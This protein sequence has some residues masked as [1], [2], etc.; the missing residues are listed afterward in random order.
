MSLTLQW[1]T[2]DGVLEAGFLEPEVQAF[3]SWGR[4]LGVR[5]R[6]RGLDPEEAPTAYMRVSSVSVFSTEETGRWDT[7]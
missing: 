6:S 3:G 5:D 4:G 7:Y 2:A 1:N